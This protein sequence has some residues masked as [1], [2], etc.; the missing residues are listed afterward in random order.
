MTLWAHRIEGVALTANVPDAD[1]IVLSLPNA[2][3]SKFST[4]IPVRHIGGSVEVGR[5]ISIAS[6]QEAVDAASALM[7]SGLPAAIHAAR[8][9]P[10]DQEG[11]HGAWLAGLGLELMRPQ[12]VT[13]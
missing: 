1:S 2:G 6:R 13:E 5:F 12:I 8:I 11:T 4:G 10:R 9:I 3:A 7:A